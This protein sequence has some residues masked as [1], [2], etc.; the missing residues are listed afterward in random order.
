LEKKN[1]DDSERSEQCPF[2]SR[3]GSASHRVFHRD[4]RCCG[5][6]AHRSPLSRKTESVA[7]PSARVSDAV[8]GRRVE[9]IRNDEQA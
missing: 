4:D 3:R 2:P 5:D 1:R 6:R 7:K 8:A 9:R